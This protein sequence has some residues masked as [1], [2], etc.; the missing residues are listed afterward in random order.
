SLLDKKVDIGLAGITINE[1]REKIIDFSHPTLDSG[2]LILVNKN[3]NQ[4]RFFESM[5]HLMGEGKRIIAPAAIAVIV[6]AI[7]FAHLLLWAESGAK[8]FSPTYFP[9]I[10]ESLWLVICSMS[11]DSFGDYVP[12]TWLGRF[13][14]TGIIVGGVATFGLL[15][16]QVSSFITL[17]KLRGK[18][19]GPGD[20]KN[21]EVATMTE[22]TSVPSLHKLGA[23]VS[24]VVKIEDAYTRLANKTVDAIVFDAPTLEAYMKS[25][26][27]NANQFEII[28]GLFDKQK[29][30][31]AMQSGSNLRERINQAILA[32]HD[33]GEYDS[34]QYKWFG[35][36]ERE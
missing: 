36:E 25:G 5:R 14:T 34:L 18:I 13:I 31:I 4:I 7:I 30:G 27:G 29:Y 10:F 32:L 2:L 16:A 26:T 17:K 8:T 11:T 20:L 21:K 35:E 9:A 15:I 22:S 19:A 1:R 6:F 3:N 33:T 24:T 28:G 12:H 23:H